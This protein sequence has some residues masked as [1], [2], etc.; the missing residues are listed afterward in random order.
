MF[1]RE[2]RILSQG[3]AAK[4][5]K[6]SRQPLNSEGAEGDFTLGRIKEGVFL[7]FKGMGRW[8]KLFHSRADMI[9]DKDLS[10]SLGSSNRRFKDAHFSSDSVFIG[11]VK[12]GATGRGDEAKFVLKTITGKSISDVN[13]S[14][15][16]VE[17]DVDLTDTSVSSYAIDTSVIESGNTLTVGSGTEFNVTEVDI[18]VG[19][20]EAS[21]STNTASIATNVSDIAGVISSFNTLVGALETGGSISEL[22][23]DDVTI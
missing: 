10:Y 17:G 11:D 14:L 12:L 21:I 7:F 13:E 23:A 8:L 5:S 9:P 19:T 18:D 4:P 2:K 6:R 22:V 15:Q 16:A 1:D 20:M 3:R